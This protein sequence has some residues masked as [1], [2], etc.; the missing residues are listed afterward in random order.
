MLDSTISK[1]LM[2]RDIASYTTYFAEVINPDEEYHWNNFSLNLRGDGGG[3][4]QLTQL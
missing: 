4:V 3:P 2:P 1:S